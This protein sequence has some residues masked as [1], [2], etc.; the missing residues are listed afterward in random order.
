M[1]N[2]NK[3]EQTNEI[4][5]LALELSAVLN[6]QHL[7]VEIYNAVIQT[8]GEIFNDE[9]RNSFETSPE[10]LNAILTTR[11]KSEVSH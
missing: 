9:Q 8:V 7:P 2:E 5:S 6:N 1:K 10:Y 4:T 3:D 11:A